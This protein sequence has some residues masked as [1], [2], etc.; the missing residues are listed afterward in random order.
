MPTA[1]LNVR[2]RTMLERPFNCGTNIS[3]CAKRTSPQTTISLR[4]LCPFV[5]GGKSPLPPTRKKRDLVPKNSDHI[6][7][8]TLEI[9]GLG[10]VAAIHRTT[11]KGESVRPGEREHDV[12]GHAKKQKNRTRTIE[13]AGDSIRL[14]SLQRV[15]FG[16]YCENSR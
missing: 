2:R 7:L 6:G 4:P 13:E 15:D 10:S 5:A 3:A 16:D 8:N 14:A 9:V 11:N 12:A 1:A